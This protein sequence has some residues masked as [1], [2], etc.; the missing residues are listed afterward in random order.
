MGQ[1]LRT[2]SL[3]YV[4]HDLSTNTYY[5]ICRGTSSLQELL[6]S[7]GSESG[8]LGFNNHLKTDITKSLKLSGDGKAKRGFGKSSS[9]GFFTSSV[10]FKDA[11]GKAV[12]VLASPW[13][14]IVKMVGNIPDGA[15]VQIVGY[16]MGATVGNMVA[17]AIIES[18]KKFKECNAIYFGPYNTFDKDGAAYLISKFPGRIDSIICANDFISRMSNVLSAIAVAGFSDSVI[19]NFMQSSRAAN[20][21]RVSLVGSNVSRVQRSKIDV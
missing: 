19:S 14:Q 5:T 20:P 17:L 21:Y 16:S 3:I 18:G 11:N 7:T 12:D 13:D 10:S 4:V 9:L 8:I 15:N 1:G 2:H 6:I